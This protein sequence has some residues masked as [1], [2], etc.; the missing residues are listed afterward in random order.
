MMTLPAMGLLLYNFPE[1]FP[2]KVSRLGIPEWE[3]IVECMVFMIVLRLPCLQPPV[4]SPPPSVIRP[5]APP[6]SL[7]TTSQ[8]TPVDG[9]T[10]DTEDTHQDTRTHARTP[11]QRRDHGDP[12]DPGEQKGADVMTLSECWIVNLLYNTKESWIKR[13]R[14]SYDDIYLEYFVGWWEEWEWELVDR[15]SVKC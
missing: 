7:V 15:G 10:S 14:V 8:H 2:I 13:D 4:D 9:Q 11:G 12:R 3:A 1:N 5:L 6:P